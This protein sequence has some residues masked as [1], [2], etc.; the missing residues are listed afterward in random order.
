MQ[1]INIKNWKLLLFT[2]VWDLKCVLM[3]DWFV[4][5][6][7][8]FTFNSVYYPVG[9]GCWIHRLLLCKEIR[10]SYP[11]EC[12]GYDAKQSD[13]EVPL[14]LELWGRR[15][16]PLMPSFPGPLW[17]GVVAFDRVLSMGQIEL[18]RVL[19]LNWI[20]LFLTS[21]LC[22]FTKLNYL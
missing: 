17:P 13:G 15:S 18:N 3:L 22:T 21:K 5:N 19:M 10:L 8:V 1:I 7:T 4:W 6:Q 12:S 2:I 14:I 16:T 11:N 20:E 9:W